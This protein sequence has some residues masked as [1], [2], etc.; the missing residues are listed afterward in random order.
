MALL[1]KSVA[2]YLSTLNWNKRFCVTNRLTDVITDNGEKV[3]YTPNMISVLEEAD[4]RIV[5]NINYLLENGFS[6]ISVKTCDTDVIVILLE[7]M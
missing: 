1:H 3:R 5:C 4:N 7:N 2:I 6:K